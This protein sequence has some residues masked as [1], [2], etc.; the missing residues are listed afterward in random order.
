METSGNAN[1][2]VVA[3]KDLDLPDN[4]EELAAALQVF[5]GPPVGPGTDGEIYVNG[6]SNGAWRQLSYNLSS[7]FDL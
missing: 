7:R 3:G 5:A 2:T 1:Q 4:P 6:F